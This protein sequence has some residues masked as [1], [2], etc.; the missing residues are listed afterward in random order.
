[1]NNSGAQQIALKYNQR[2][3]V[4]LGSEK[5]SLEC[6]E[7]DHSIATFKLHVESEPQQ[8]VIT[9]TIGEYAN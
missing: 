7:F 5:I 3:E 2:R 8:V 9:A 4:F 1:M 6:K